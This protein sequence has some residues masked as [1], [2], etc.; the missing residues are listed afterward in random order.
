MYL[1]DNTE[2]ESKPRFRRSLS[3]LTILAVFSI[4]AAALVVASGTNKESD[5]GNSAIDPTAAQNTVATKPRSGHSEYLTNLTRKALRDGLGKDSVMILEPN[6][7]PGRAVVAK[8]LLG[9]ASRKGGP[10]GPRLSATG[11]TAARSDDRNT[12]YVGPNSSFKISADGTKFRFRG[13]ID[14]PNE[15]ARARSGGRIIEKDELEKIGRRFVS[16]A[17]RDFVKLGSDESLVFLG[18]KYLRDEGLSADAKQR[19]VEVTSNVAVF[20]REIRGVPVIGSGS[21]I[22][23]WFANDRQPVAFDV[24]WPVYKV[25]RTRQSVLTSNRYSSRDG[26]AFRMWLC[27]FWSN[28]AR[29]NCSIRLRDPL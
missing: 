16:D 15:I 4:M 1:G 13:N 29:L 10:F 3:G 19:D 11:L 7:G 18:A 22:A 25:G 9:L 24:D 21:K 28:E 20:G 27:R 12:A 5:P 17:L 8:Q 2:Q 26:V 6:R 23:V 14:D